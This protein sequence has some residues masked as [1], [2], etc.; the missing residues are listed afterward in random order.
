MKKQ[1]TEMEQALQASIDRQFVNSFEGLQASAAKT[2]R[3]CRFNADDLLIRE[4]EKF[5]HCNTKSVQYRFKPLVASFRNA[6]IGLKIALVMGELGET[7][8]AVR[9]NLGPDSHCPE[10][11]S[12]EVEVADAVIRLMNYAHDRKLRLAQAI[13]AKNNHNRTR[14][15]HQRKARESAHGKRF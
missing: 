14:P 6:R 3:K 4:F 13:V 1:P 2:N 12:E 7:L 10:F 11:T 15:D 9:K 8:E 5:L